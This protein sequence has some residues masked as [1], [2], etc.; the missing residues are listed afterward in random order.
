MS[1]QLASWTAQHSQASAVG[2]A[3]LGQLALCSHP[4]GTPAYEPTWDDLERWTGYKR[5]TVAKG[6]AELRRLG[7]IKRIGGGGQGTPARYRVVVGTLCAPDIDCRSC[8]V[9]AE[10]GADKVQHMDL[11]RS[12]KGPRDARKGPPDA[13]KGPPGGPSTD[14]ETDHP[15]GGTSPHRESGAAFATDGAAPEP[16]QQEQE[17]A[18]NGEAPRR[19]PTDA[20]KQG[21]W[22]ALHP[23][24]PRPSTPEER[25]AEERAKRARARQLLDDGQRST[26]ERQRSGP[27]LTERHSA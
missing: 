7:E 25:A 16:E 13:R 4:D 5:S 14:T 11:K 24:R 21:W 19:R 22:D 10:V 9:L 23:G 8:A 2:R 3:I 26:E 27:A 1:G 17:P 18:D 20:D 12:G 6:L 15:Q